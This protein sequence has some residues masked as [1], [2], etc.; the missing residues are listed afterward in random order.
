[1]TSHILSNEEI[2]KIKRLKNT[3]ILDDTIQKKLQNY[4][5]VQPFT[6][7][8]YKTKKNKNIR[9]LNKKSKETKYISD[10]YRFKEIPKNIKNIIST[11]LEDNNISIQTLCY[12][13]QIPA[14]IL[15]S[16]LNNNGI[17]DNNN[18]SKSGFSWSSKSRFGTYN[19]SNPN[20]SS[21]K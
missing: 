5:K 10:P 17:I 12:K 8:I 2:N 16:Y 19:I 11:F 4:E 21:F 15:D 20:R 18:L 6:K 14:Y 1:M 3:H 13:L 9:K 7:V